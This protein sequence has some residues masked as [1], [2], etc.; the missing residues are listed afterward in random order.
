MKGLIVL[1]IAAIL[2]AL[3]ATAG[4]D[5]YEWTD[6]NGIKHY[7]NFA[8]PEQAGTLIKTEELPVRSPVR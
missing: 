3:S 8:P 1:S 5:I 4:A 6:K 7:S 2:F